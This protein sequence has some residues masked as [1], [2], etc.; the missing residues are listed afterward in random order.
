MKLSPITLLVLLCSVAYCNGAFFA[1]GS[2]GIIPKG[3][4][5]HD[6]YCGY[7]ALFFIVVKSCGWGEGDCDYD[8]MCK[9]DLV[10][11]TNNCK[12]MHMATEKEHLFDG[13]DDCCYEKGSKCPGCY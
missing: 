3:S 6:S 2:L 11:G 10:C 9:G 8:V 7:D 4:L 12:A 5:G 1:T 13:H